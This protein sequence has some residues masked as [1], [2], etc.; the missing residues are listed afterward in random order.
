MSF[1]I[2]NLSIHGFWYV[3]GGPETNPL[4]ILKEICVKKTCGT[5][6]APVSTRK[7]SVTMKKSEPNRWAAQVG[8]LWLTF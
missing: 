8:C 2:R 3:P 1:Y 5:Y 6:E 7:D 4:W